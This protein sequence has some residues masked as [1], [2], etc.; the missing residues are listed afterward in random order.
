MTQGLLE[1]TPAQVRAG[2][3]PIENSLSTYL[4]HGFSQISGFVNPLA[5]D[6]TFTLGDIQR[7]TMAPGPTL[8]IGVGQGQYLCLLSHL[9]A[10]PTMTVAVDPA[11][12]GP[13]DAPHIAAFE[14]NIDL[15]VRR[16][17][18]LRLCARASRLLTPRQLLAL[19]GEPFQF[20]SLNGSRMLD[21]AAHDLRLAQATV[22]DRGIVVVDNVPHPAAPGVWEAFVRYGKDPGA[23]LAP[24]LICGNKL[25]MAQKTHAAHY[26]STLLEWCRTQR[27]GA[28]G[29]EIDA[30]RQQLIGIAQEARL[31]GYDILVHRKL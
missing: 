13:A 25:F 14:R 22:A 2:A 29:F 31:F 15:F 23:T 16:P 28:V 18:L 3:Q 21:D 8:E 6:I 7:D 9:P 4:L 24:F 30:F 1:T 19:A 17:D 5:R 12:D 11:L 27:A 26:H 10:V 20:I